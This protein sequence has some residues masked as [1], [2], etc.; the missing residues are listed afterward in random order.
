MKRCTTLAVLAAFLLTGCGSMGG[1]KQIFSAAF[2][3]AKLSDEMVSG[4]TLTEAEEI[5]ELSGLR[6]AAIAAL[7]LPSLVADQLDAVSVAVGI[8]GQK[9]QRQ[10]ICPGPLA[11]VCREIPINTEVRVTG[12]SLSDGRFVAT[13]VGRP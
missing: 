2:T 4:F 11:A 10:V 5:E 3:G 7:G 12:R 13:R 9:D 1:L 6:D 8:T